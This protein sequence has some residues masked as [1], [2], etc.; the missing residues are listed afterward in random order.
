MY[1]KNKEKVKSVSIHSTGPFYGG[2]NNIVSTKII[3][4]RFYV[5]NK[6]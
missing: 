2:I 3:I 5:T 6:N 1:L 4:L